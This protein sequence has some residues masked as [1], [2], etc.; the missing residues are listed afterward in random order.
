MQNPIPPLLLISFTVRPFTL[1]SAQV[2]N[3]AYLIVAGLCTFIGAAGYY[4]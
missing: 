2:L 1:L 4:M 3:A